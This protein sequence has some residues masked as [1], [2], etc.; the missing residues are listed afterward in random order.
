MCGCRKKNEQVVSAMTQSVMRAGTTSVIEDD[1]TTIQYIGAGSNL[2]FYGSATKKR[3]YFTQGAIAKINKDDAN[4]FLKLRSN[5]KSVFVEV[6]EENVRF[7]IEAG[8]IMSE[9]ANT[10]TK[11]PNPTPTVP[12]QS[13]ANE[14]ET[15]TNESGDVEGEVVEDE[16]S[17]NY[18][19]N[20]DDTEVEEKPKRGRKKKATDE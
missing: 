20:L 2:L 16:P 3:Y 9:L 4:T 13:P 17:T 14:P 10:P 8:E 7:A 6:K 19:V 12:D 18:P 15:E 1:G 11:T 5:G